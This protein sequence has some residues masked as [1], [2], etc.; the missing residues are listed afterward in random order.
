MTNDTTP[1]GNSDWLETFGLKLKD[2]VSCD[3][4]DCKAFATHFFKVNCC[5]A[6]YLVC[7]PCMYATARTAKLAIETERLVG[8]KFCGQFSDPNGW[9]NRPEPL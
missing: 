2:N 7:M 5:G 9:M 3:G 8:C 4:M 1:I 6:V